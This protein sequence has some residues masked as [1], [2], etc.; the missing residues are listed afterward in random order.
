MKIRE[1]IIIKGI[2]QGVGFRPF[3]HRLV[4]NYS[5]SGWVFN[6]NQGVEIEVEGKEE[7][8]N[9]FIS[10][11]KKKLPPLARI[12]NIEVNQLPLVGYKGF[13]IKK[14]IVK[15]EDSFVLISPDISICK[16]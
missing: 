6:S 3:I 14:S 12:E 9:S 11:V 13:S 10:D 5:L 8:L 16:D 2:V 1:N 15:E 7:E 4:Q